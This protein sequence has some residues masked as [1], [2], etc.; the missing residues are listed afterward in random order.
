[1]IYAVYVIADLYGILSVAAALIQ[2]K[3]E[4][5][6]ITPCIMICGGCIMIFAVILHILNF[7]LSWLIALIGGL[8]ISTAAFINGK[9]GEKFHPVHHIIRL[10]V[11]SLL[12]LG[13]VLF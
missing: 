5:K 3:K 1:M 7:S 9:S 2:I 13:F 11:T 4:N 12:T 8:L 6:K 10:I